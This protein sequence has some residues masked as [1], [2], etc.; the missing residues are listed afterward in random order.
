M[1]ISNLHAVIP[2]NGAST[3]RHRIGTAA[4]LP[5]QFGQRT[6]V[7]TGFRTG[8]WCLAEAVLGNIRHICSCACSIR[9]RLCRPLF[10]EFERGLLVRHLDHG[11]ALKQLGIHLGKFPVEEDS[12]RHLVGAGGVGLL[13][14]HQLLGHFLDALD[15]FFGKRALGCPERSPHGRPPAQRTL[16]LLRLIPN[17]CLILP[18][19]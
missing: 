9:G 15:L 7:P 14:L 18:G 19:R 2:G 8:G 4:Q 17:C 6:D 16:L 10:H 3:K 12:Q 11:C 13:E 5:P 1:Q